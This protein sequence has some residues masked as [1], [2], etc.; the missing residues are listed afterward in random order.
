[1]VV[2]STLSVSV[3]VRRVTCSTVKPTGSSSNHRPDTGRLLTVMLTLP[4]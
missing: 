1:M 3:T 2:N 4:T